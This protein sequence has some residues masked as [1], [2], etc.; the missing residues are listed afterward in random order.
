MPAR[1]AKFALEVPLDVSQ[2]GS[3]AEPGK[4][5]SVVFDFAQ[6]PGSLQILVGPAT[7]SA[8]DL[9]KLQTISVNVPGRQSAG[10]PKLSIDPVVISPF[11]WWWWI[12]WCRSFVIRGRVLCADGSPVG[13]ATVYAYDIDWWFWWTS[14]EQLGY[15][16][17]DANGAFEIDFTWCCGWWPWWWWRD[18][19]WQIDPELITRVSATLEQDPRIELGHVTTQPSLSVF[20]ELLGPTAPAGGPLSPSGAEQLEQLRATIAPKLPAS[21][22]LSALRVWPWWPWWPW[23]D[24][25]V[26]LIFK[27][28]QSCKK[29]GT[30]LLR[31]GIDQVRFDIA[32][33]TEVTLVANDL[34]CCAPPPRPEGQCIDIAKLCSASIE[35]VGGNPGALPLPVGRM[36]PQGVAPGTPSADGDRAFG[37]TVEIFNANDVIGVDYYQIQYY[38]GADWVGLP[39]G[40]A[41]GFYREWLQPAPP[42]TLWPSGAV[43]F[44]FTNQVVK[45]SHG[46]EVNVVE[47]RERYESSTG[48]PVGAYWT[49]NELLVVPIDSSKFPDQD[50][51]Y[52]FRVVGWLD[53]GGDEVEGPVKKPG[54]NYTPLGG[55]ILP[56]CYPGRTQDNGWVLTFNNW[57][58]NPEPT[59]G[60]SS[61]KVGPTEVGVCGTVD[62]ASGPLLVKFMVEDV[63]GNLGSYELRAISGDR[64]PVDLLALGTLTLL[65]GD[66]FGPTYGQA[67]AGGATA[68]VWKG[69]TMLLTIDNAADAFPEPCCYDLELEAWSRT[70]VDCGGTT[71]WSRSDFTIGVGVCQ[72]PPAPLPLDGEPVEPRATS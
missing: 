54:V 34:A 61:V 19:V 2:I 23:R 29:A 72:P 63:S 22:E 69:G 47:T 12:E 48:L 50:G 18:R 17:T 16:T 55:E 28:S 59:T 14:T 56:V 26:D 44:P 46:E 51:T 30:V 60:I 27:V 25:G 62:S 68:P 58:V 39:P 4:P 1:D 24:C 31:E 37:G 57:A 10:K 5:A 3:E 70:V 40:A 11:Y 15:A 67:L 38:D 43:P 20:S 42:P 9:V 45:G 32:Q 21:A 36:Y 64:P 53:A 49:A 33:T 65:S 6:P 13:G 35:Q 8:Y 71:Y 7:A 66:A 52:Q 41:E